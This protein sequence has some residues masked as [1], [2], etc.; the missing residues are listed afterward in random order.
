MKR[1]VNFSIIALL[2][3]MLMVFCSCD[4]N[5]DSSYE[6]PN[7]NNEIIE[8]PT[9][10][11]N[12]TVEQ[13]SSDN[14]SYTG[15][16]FTEQNGNI[17]VF[18]DAEKTTTAYEK[19][20]ELDSLGRCGVA[21]AVLGIETMPAQNEDRGSISNVTPSGWIQAKYDIVDGGYLYNR[22]HMIG[23]QLSAENDNK[24]NL[25]TGTRYFNVEGMLPFENMV[26]DYIKETGNHVAYRVTPVYEGSNLV[27]NGVIMEAW[28]IEDNGDGICFNVLV[29]NVQPGIQINYATGESW[30]TGETPPETTTPDI[31]SEY[32]YYV[33]NIS[34]KKIHYPD[35][36]YAKNIKDENKSEYTGDLQELINDGY[37]TC[38]VCKPE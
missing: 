15:V 38:G 30:L 19:Y 9:D 22:A 18:S 7:D 1:K 2:L 28:S 25:I 34:S 26:A 6:I 37:T 13:P 14:I 16:A 5:L 3:A 11:N 17:P 35:C 31:K 24:K 12:E 29:H 21:I 27:C 23:W 33:L 10:N 32:D 8:S 20:S 36:S 4:I